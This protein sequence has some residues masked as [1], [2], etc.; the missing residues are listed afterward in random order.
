MGAQKNVKCDLL[1]DLQK[2][3]SVKAKLY[4]ILDLNL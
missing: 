1:A 4:P 2:M 3:I